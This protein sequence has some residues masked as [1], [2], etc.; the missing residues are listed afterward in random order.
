MASVLDT[1]SDKVLFT[2]MV[3]KINKDLTTYHVWD[4]LSVHLTQVLIIDIWTREIES[5][6]KT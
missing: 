4:S 2:K 6:R 5:N 3:Y 1:H